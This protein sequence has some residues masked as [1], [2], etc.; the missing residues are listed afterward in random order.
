MQIRAERAQSFIMDRVTPLRPVAAGIAG[1]AGEASPSRRGAA[2]E[3]AASQA[4]PESQVGFD[5]L[6]AGCVGARPPVVSGTVHL[7]CWGPSTCCVGARPPVVSGPVHLL[8]RGPSTCCVGT[9]PPVV[10]GPVHLLCGPTHSL[11][12]PPGPLHSDG[13][14]PPPPHQCARGPPPR[15]AQRPHGNAAEGPAPAGLRQQV[16]ACLC[17]CARTCVCVCLRA[18]VCVCVRER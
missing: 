12:P 17:V 7:L 14:A 8:C 11:T 2:A 15:P 16:S 9:R 5:G 6:A 1:T 4:L 10:L 18:H 13:R 3:A